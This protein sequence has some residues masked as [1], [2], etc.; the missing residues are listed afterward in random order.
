MRGVII[1]GSSRSQG[2]TRKVVDK[3]LESLDFDLIDLKEKD[4]GA[5]DYEF[6]NQEDDFLPLMKTIVTQ[7]DFLLFATPVYWYSMSGIMKHFFDRFSDCLKI[8]KD[9][10]RKLR[11]KTMAMISCGYDKV[12]VPGFSEPFS[13]TAKYLGM[14]YFGNLHTWM[15]DDAELEEEVKTAI[16]A[17]AD[18]ISQ[19]NTH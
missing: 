1:F 19:Y 12:T 15:E 13:A 17:F 9:V 16:S 4:I 11:G 6:K 10:G 18:A 8:E 7:Y 3:L 14:N 5:F 2:N